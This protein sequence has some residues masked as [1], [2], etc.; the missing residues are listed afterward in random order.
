MSQFSIDAFRA[1]LINGLARNNLFLVQGNFPGSNTSS[2]QGAAAVAGSLFGG[3]VSSAINSAAAAIGGG[4]NPSAQVSF[5]CKATKLPTATQAINRAMYMGREFKYP[6]DKTF[7]DWSI[8]CY[9]D[10]TYSLRKAFEGWLNLIN[11]NRTNVGAN[12][13]N[14]FMT[15]WTV[16]P[17]TRE[18]N[19]IT[20]YKMVGCW[21]SAFGD[22]TLDMN[23]DTNPSTFD[24]TIAY[25]Y[26]EINGV[27][28]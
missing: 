12:S 1:N 6:G 24:V 7:A 15:D 11:T 19:P 26:Y 25:Q 17:L 2:I 9:N 3:A 28:T 18:G 13:L 10:G 20:T 21:P 23:A 27:T 14:Q 5:L 4:G 22:V 16:S 8:T